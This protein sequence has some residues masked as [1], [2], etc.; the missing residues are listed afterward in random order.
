MKMD[1]KV[2]RALGSEKLK[3]NN[4]ARRSSTKPT[5]KSNGKHLPAAYEHIPIGIVE[6]SLGGKY[7]NANEEFCNIVA[8]EK[9]EL[10]TLGIKDLTFEEDYPI[11]I[12]LHQQLI[13]GKIPFYKLEKRYVRKDGE[14]AWVELTRSI[15]RNSHGK[16]LYTVGA[17]LDVTERKRADLEI[18]NISRL[19]AENPNQL[20]RLTPDGK[21]LYA[22]NAATSLLDFWKQENDQTIPSKFQ[23]QVAEAFA[24]GLKKEIEIEQ[25][26]K[27]FSCTLVPIREAGY[28]NFYGNDITERKR[29]EE[30]LRASEALYRRLLA[31]F[32]VEGSM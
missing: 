15:V 13:A 21:I 2:K 16:A 26:G 17:V 5:S 27:T 19:P 28:V 3:A 23:K 31:V 24:S 22:N 14:I 30:K 25:N 8:Y 32:R 29:A 20:M 1:R 11:D 18:K 12:N 9:Q 4:G 6:S 10:L 7:I